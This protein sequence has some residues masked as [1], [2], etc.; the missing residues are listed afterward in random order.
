[1]P[2]QPITSIGNEFKALCKDFVAKFFNIELATDNNFSEN[3]RKSGKYPKDSVGRVVIANFCEWTKIPS[4]NTARSHYLLEGAAA[5]DAIDAIYKLLPHINAVNNVLIGAINKLHSTDQGLHLLYEVDRIEA[6]LALLSDAQVSNTN[7]NTKNNLISLIKKLK[8][9]HFFKIHPDIKA[10]NLHRI[11]AHDAGWN[12]TNLFHYTNFSMDIGKGWCGLINLGVDGLSS[13]CKNHI[14]PKAIF[15]FVGCIVK[16]PAIPIFFLKMI[17]FGA[18]KLFSWN[19]VCALLKWCTCCCRSTKVQAIEMTAV[20]KPNASPR[21]ASPR[22]IKAGDASP[23]S[24]R[25]AASN[26]NLGPSAVPGNATPRSRQVSAMASS[27]AYG[28]AAN[29]ANGGGALGSPHSAVVSPTHGRPRTASRSRADGGSALAPPP[30]LGLGIPAGA[31]IT[32]DPAT[33]MSPTAQLSTGAVVAT[34][35]L[36]V[37]PINR[38]RSGITAGPG[39]GGAAAPTAI[40]THLQSAHGKQASMSM[41]DTANLRI[42]IDKVP[43]LEITPLAP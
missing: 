10:P 20:S 34:T 40:A 6:Q 43:A 8:E 30:S 36:N 4:Q 32:P 29:D 26:A 27:C 24:A 42:N 28:A 25:P 14:V 23:R 37:K 1:M 7:H 15:N 9:S 5:A 13:L 35:L 17:T 33:P 16:L 41:F 3:L 39:S 12:F 22:D 31:V 38:I 21:N 11:V 18:A 19:N 2:I